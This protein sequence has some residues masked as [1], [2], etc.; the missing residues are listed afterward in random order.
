MLVEAVSHRRHGAALPT[1]SSSFTATGVPRARKLGAGRGAAWIPRNRAHFCFLGR[2]LQPR[3]QS[4]TRPHLLGRPRLQE[5][6]LWEPA[7]LGQGGAPLACC[8]PRRPVPRTG[9]QGL[10]SWG[11]TLPLL[12]LAL[13][14]SPEP[15]HHIV[16]TYDQLCGQRPEPASGS[17]AC[18]LSGMVSP[19]HCGCPRDIHLSHVLGTPRHS[20]RGGR[21]RVPA[22]ADP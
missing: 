11:E 10:S 17:F 15:G 8:P 18:P 9:E 12:L 2:R 22:Q 7:A 16:L 6:P 21:S 14:I 1:P 20:G 19:D 3:G 4:D 13:W 5:A